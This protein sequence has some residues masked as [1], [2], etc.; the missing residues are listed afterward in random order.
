MKNFEKISQRIDSYEKAMIELQGTLTA[1][2]A[3]SPVN[4]G[5]GE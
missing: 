1:I 2:P 5:E 4:G 3:L